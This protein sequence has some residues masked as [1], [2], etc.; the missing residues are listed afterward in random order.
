MPPVQ[1]GLVKPIA[2]LSRK[3]LPSL[4]DLPTAYEQGLKFEASTWFGFFLPQGHA[5]C[6][7][8][9][10]ARCDRHRD[11]YARRYRNSLRQPAPSWC[12]PSTRLDGLS[13]KHHRSR[14]RE[15]RRA[16]QGRR[17]VD[18]VRLRLARRCE[19]PPPCQLPAAV[20]VPEEMTPRRSWVAALDGDGTCVL[21]RRPSRPA[22]EQ[23]A[24][25]APS[26]VIS[27][28]TAG[29]A[30]DIIGAHRT[31]SASRSSSAKRFSSRTEPGAGG[32]LAAASVAQ[33]EPD[34]YTLL[35]SS[36]RR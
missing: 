32:T 35:L 33:A 16:A 27:P 12:R 24:E 28:F 21:A 20:M 9:K 15:K 14:N 23:L 29:D 19:K 31:R 34:G 36:A 2:M 25:H 5:G 22:H 11:Q 10:A 7:H 13:A 30:N 6:D 1:A 3:R 26:Q 8:Q 17:N 4:P 18:R